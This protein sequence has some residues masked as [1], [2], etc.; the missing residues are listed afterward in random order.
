MGARHAG[1]SVGRKR[2]KVECGDLENNSATG[3]TSSQARLALS[4]TLADENGISGCWFVDIDGGCRCS[5]KRRGTNQ[6]LKVQRISKS[7]E[8]FLTW[9][10][11]IDFP[12]TLSVRGVLEPSCRDV[13][14]EDYENLVEGSVVG[15]GEGRVTC[16]CLV[17]NGRSGSEAVFNV[18]QEWAYVAL[19]ESAWLK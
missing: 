5:S 9:I 6:V 3:P 17:E 4:M 18:L 10:T 8:D 1:K 2:L 12:G 19:F 13:N 11:A 14:V 16:Q 7:V 15:W